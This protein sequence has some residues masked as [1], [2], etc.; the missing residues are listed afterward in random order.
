[1][2]ITHLAEAED[3]AENQVRLTILIPHLEK[4]ESGAENHVS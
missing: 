2:F 1:M 3:G 4:P